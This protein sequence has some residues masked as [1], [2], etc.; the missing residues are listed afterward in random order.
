MT[1]AVGDALSQAPFKHRPA[2]VLK[3]FRRTEFIALPNAPGAAAS[4]VDFVPRPECM[5]A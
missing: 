4:K 1:A 3:D 2:A 5:A